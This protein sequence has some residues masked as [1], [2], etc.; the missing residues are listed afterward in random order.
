M[1]QQQPLQT[2]FFIRLQKLEDYD[3]RLNSLRDNEWIIKMLCIE[4]R[5]DNDDPNPHWHFTLLTTPLLL[6]TLRARLRLIFDK[7]NGNGHMS[8][9]PWDGGI[10]ANAYMFHEQ[11]DAAPYINKGYTA[12]EIE[13][14]RNHNNGVQQVTARRRKATLFNA[15][16][17][18]YEHSV[19]QNEG[20]Y[21]L[22][23]AIHTAID[24]AQNKN[25]LMPTTQKMAQTWFTAKLLVDMEHNPRA[26][27]YN[28]EAYGNA[29]RR[30][31]T[32]GI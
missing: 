26:F 10:E 24:W 31:L 20:P 21:G 1:P 32:D 16:Y 4:H 12:E 28:F 23:D 9:K 15:I 13:D 25:Q 27:E 2:T 6:P 8:I 19:V 5:G 7:G 14:F 18:R 30:R 17:V 11:A 29:V 22:D 3:G